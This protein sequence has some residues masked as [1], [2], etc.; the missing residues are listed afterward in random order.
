MVE[1]FRLSELAALVARA[2][3]AMPYDGQPSGRVREV[4]DARTIRYYTTLGL[5]DR[6]LTMQGRT[7]FYGKRHVLQLV[8]IKRLQARGL[9]LV[10]IQRHLLGADD[11]KLA[12]WAALPSGFWEQA[13]ASLPAGVAPS[14]DELLAADAPS[15]PPPGV[16]G[17]ELRRPRRAFWAAAP[18]VAAAECSVHEPSGDGRGFLPRPAVVVTL[19]EG[20]SLV[21]DGEWAVGCDSAAWGAIEP[22]VRGLVAAL[23][24]AGIVEG[25]TDGR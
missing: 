4:P 13:V 16:P 17:E 22:E 9:T 5:L 19:G 23:Q 3:A 6:P 25:R 2:L 12:R 15:Q 11:R 8:A 21:I 20:V 10:E 7:A 18:E 1:H 24:R 14:P